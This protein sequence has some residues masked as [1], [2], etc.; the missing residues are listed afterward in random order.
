MPLDIKCARIIEKA[1]VIRRIVVAVNDGQ[2]PHL[3]DYIKN[4]VDGWTI[5]TRWTTGNLFGEFLFLEVNFAEAAPH[6]G[7]K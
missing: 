1:E 4:C 7:Y 5:E 3:A 2:R 6:P